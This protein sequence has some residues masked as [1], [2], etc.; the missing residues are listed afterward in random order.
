VSE[1]SVY[2]AL[3]AVIQKHMQRN[4]RTLIEHLQPV[5]ITSDKE[6]ETC[7]FFP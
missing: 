3:S 5:H 7:F 2:I 6:F 4:T 1:N